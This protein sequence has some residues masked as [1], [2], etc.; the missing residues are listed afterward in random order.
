MAGMR[1]FLVM[2][3][4]AALMHAALAQ[5]IATASATYFSRTATISS[6]CG[7]A[8]GTSPGTRIVGVV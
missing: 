1:K 4:L 3:S 2:A 7:A 8:R 5:R 6:K